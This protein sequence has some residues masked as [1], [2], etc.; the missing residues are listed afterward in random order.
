MAVSTIHV[1]RAG[2]NT[3]DPQ[4][5][6]VARGDIV[7][8]VPR[9]SNVKVK[10]KFKNGKSPFTKQELSGGAGAIVT[11]TVKS[12]AAA[13]NYAYDNMTS[14]LKPDADPLIIVK[15]TVIP[16]TQAAKKR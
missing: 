6:V 14:Q 16:K 3:L 1:I 13:D 8:W 10:V 15:D 11:G 9:A 7:H 5:L 12:D 4:D 2:K